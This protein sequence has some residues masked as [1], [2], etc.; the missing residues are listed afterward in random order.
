MNRFN[1]CCGANTNPPGRSR[2]NQKRAAN[3]SDDAQQERLAQNEV[4]F[5]AVNEKIAAVALNLGGAEP[6]HFICECAT[7]ACFESLA[8]T[9][10]EYEDVRRNGSR[11]NGYS[12]SGGSNRHD[13]GRRS[14]TM[15]L[16]GAR[17]R[18]SSRS[19]AR[20][21]HSTGLDTI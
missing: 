12:T 18:D 11:V 7:T 1:R 21:T 10:R 6:Y 4:T 8:L 13:P 17:C 9:L 19:R 20:M 5:R 2:S 3:R 14:P 16:R 15:T